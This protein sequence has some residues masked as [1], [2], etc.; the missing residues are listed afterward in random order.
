MHNDIRQAVESLL[1]I[2][3]TKKK[4][5]LLSEDESRGHSKN[6]KWISLIRIVFR[7]TFSVCCRLK[8][9]RTYFIKYSLTMMMIAYT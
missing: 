9:R 7:L 6:V 1:R 5:I 3:E 8:L 4:S 2:K